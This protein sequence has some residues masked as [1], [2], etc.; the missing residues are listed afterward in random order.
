MARDL[1][2][3]A[4]YMDR[5]FRKSEESLGTTLRAREMLQERWRREL[6]ALETMQASRPLKPPH[7][8][9]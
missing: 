7:Q 9:R 2:V 8:K 3:Q 6:E 1:G 5:A 4:D